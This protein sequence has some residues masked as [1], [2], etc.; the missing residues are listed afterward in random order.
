VTRAAL[1][2]L[3]A[4]ALALPSTAAA[5]HGGRIA[6]GLEDGASP[7]E[8]GARVRAATGG[9]LLRGI[10]PLRALVV[11]VPDVEAAVARASRLAGVAYAEPAGTRRRLFFQPN[12][13]LAARQW[14]LGAVRAFDFWPEKPV[15]DAPVL[16]AVVDSGVDGSHPELAGRIAG[17]RSFVDEPADVDG[18]GHGTMVA[19]EIAA[20][21]D[22]Q[23]GIAG[24]A[25]PAQL[26]V[27]KVVGANGSISLEAEARA[28]RWAV[29]NGARVV[30]LSLGGPRDPQNPERDTYSELE[31]AAIDYALSK[32]AVVVAATGNCASVCPYRYASYPA[33]LPHVV[34]VSALDQNGKTP[35][36]SNR[37][38][39][40]NDLAAPGRGILSTFPVALT[41]AA[42]G[43]PGYSS[44]ATVEDYRRGEGTSFA[45]PLVSAAAA[46]LLSVRPDLEASQVGA[47]LTATAEDVQEPGRDRQTGAGRLS[48]Q[49]ALAALGGPLPP[50]DAFETNDDAAGR[51]YPLYFR[52][53]RRTV[54]ATLD[55]YQDLNDVYRVRLRTGER[56]AAV[57]RGPAGTDTNLVLWRPGA[58]SVAAFPPRGL[59]AELSRRPGARERIV[60]RA[61]VAG[62][63]YLQ[64]KLSEGAGGPYRLELTKSRP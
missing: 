30:N 14:Y 13:P 48:V 46:L 38:A 22:N 27:A 15:F 37:D 44:C 59:V 17:K 6:V 43:E 64:V 36:F 1:V 49:A 19:G 4:A 8:V 24:L 31:Q 57:L 33:A 11:A 54:E 28:I 26:L 12:D 23:Q 61:A 9:R 60:H 39:V 50:A 16:V 10:G 18:I 42:C 55:R 2:A 45:A 40:Y 56:L 21:L 3:A 32:G 53:L 52:G 20:A 47:L 29:D 58:T 5:S 41:D 63:Y 7:A 35:G 51:S 62:W 34:G 25:F